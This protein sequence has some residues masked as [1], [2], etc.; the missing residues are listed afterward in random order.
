MSSRLFQNIRERQG[1]AYAVF[2]EINPYSDAGMLSVYAGTARNNVERVLRSVAAEFRSLKQ[3]PVS[4]EELR[5]AKDHLKG[6]LVLSLESSGAR[7]SALARQEMYFG[8]FFT[9]E[10]I[11][12]AVEAVT[13]E[14][15]QQI[16]RECF[17]PEKIAVSV[18]GPLN[19]FRLNRDLVAC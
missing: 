13:R 8:R 17:Q 1:L 10:D 18:V 6:S 3:E 9:I 15:I 5:R 19:G 16:A 12:A 11:K 7:M 2:S 14:Q 4:E